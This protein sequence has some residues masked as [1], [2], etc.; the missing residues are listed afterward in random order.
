MSTQQEQSHDALGRVHILTGEG[1][2]KT[3]AALGLAMRAAGGGLKVIMI[4]F[5]KRSNRYG[6]LKAALKLA[7]EFEIV[8]MGPECVRL[9]ED[10]SADATCTG[11]MK[12]HVDPQNLRIADLDAARKGMDLAERAL[13]EDEYDLVILDEINYAIGFNLVA[14]E[15]V[16]ALLKRKR[17]DVEVVLTGR[18]AHPLLLEAADYVTEMHEVKHP[19]RRGEQ[20]R[21]GI[22]Y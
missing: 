21:R 20:A 8:Q 3:T 10:P 1:K 19:W 7:P 14:P 15:E 16:Q 17:R 13:T 5:L 2:G 6:E 12:C 18:N 11:C 4:Q 22:E 9:L